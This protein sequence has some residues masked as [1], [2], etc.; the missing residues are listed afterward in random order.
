MAVESTS[1]PLAV[2]PYTAVTDSTQRWLLKLH[3]DVEGRG[4]DIILTRDDYLG[5]PAT[6]AALFGLVQAMLL[7]RH[8]L[9]VG[10]SLDDEDF[11]RIV[12]EVKAARRSTDDASTMGTALVLGVDP[13]QTLLWED[14]LDVV[15]V[16][17]IE[18]GD[19]DANAVPGD[20][21][22]AARRLQI[23]L[24]RVGYLAADM[25]G[26]VLDETFEGLLDDDE[27]TMADSLRALAATPQ[28]AGPGWQKVQALLRE[29][30]L[31][32]DLGE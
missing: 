1:A 29:M 2:L 10:Y 3:G 8:L 30:G 32:H 26:F 23:F 11:H 25:T 7:T 17:S 24:D 12:H 16:E 31:P 14:S 18:T 13:L 28:Q 27:R 6:H 15:P 5:A 20:V 22:A 9:F 4:S 19:A 21:A